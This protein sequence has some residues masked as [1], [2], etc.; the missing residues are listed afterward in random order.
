MISFVY[1][2]EY[3]V[4]GVNIGKDVAIAHIHAYAI[5]EYYDV[6]G[7]K[8]QASVHFKAVRNH[9]TAQDIIEVA[10]EVYTYTFRG[11]ALR[12]TLCSIVARDMRRLSGDE[13]FTAELDNADDFPG[14]AADLL[15]HST[16][17]DQ[18]REHDA[19][20]MY[21]ALQVRMQTMQE[22]LRAELGA[23]RAQ[24]LRYALVGRLCGTCHRA[25]TMANTQVEVHRGLEPAGTVFPGYIL[26]CTR[27]G[28]GRTL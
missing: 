12:F 10:R 26:R 9:G 3:E 2:G 1:K 19:G 27:C 18:K 17:Y 28:W 15:I 23:A 8:E 7:L 24:G 20:I 16:C 11:D 4:E 14:F 5:G 22:E 25:L 21:H 6:A 13:A